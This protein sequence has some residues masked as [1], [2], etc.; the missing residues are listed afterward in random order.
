[1]TW[2][3]ALAVAAAAAASCPCLFQFS[4]SSLQWLWW[5]WLLRS[6]WV[7]VAVAV[8]VVVVVV[9]VVVAI[10]VATPPA[11]DQKRIRRFHRLRVQSTLGAKMP[12]GN[13]LAPCLLSEGHRHG[14][15]RT[16]H[17]SFLLN[18]LIEMRLD[19]KDY[20]GVARKKRKPYLE[21]TDAAGWS[22]RAFWAS[23]RTQKA[24]E[25]AEKQQREAEKHAEIARSSMQQAQAAMLQSRVNSRAYAVKSPSV[26]PYLHFC[27]ELGT[28]LRNNRKA[29]ESTPMLQLRRFCSGLENALD[30]ISRRPET[31][32][33]RAGFRL[34]DVPPIQYPEDP[35]W[36]PDVPTF[37]LPSGMDDGFD[38]ELLLPIQLSVPEALLWLTPS[39]PCHRRH[40]G[41]A[42]FL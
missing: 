13:G 28:W 39:S 18:K 41:H 20:W 17:S 38:P 29:G 2:F 23:M 7:T 24:L 19:N 35:Q 16:P 9:V 22:S 26:Q 31:L 36:R 14:V 25:E 40:H 5:S 27:D 42:T 15:C 34:F 32:A 4:S 6:L 3:V 21:P 10:V 33:T 30:Q 37:H 1:M 8:A 12:C 11:F